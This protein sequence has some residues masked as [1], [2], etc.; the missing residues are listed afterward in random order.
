M[1]ELLDF[2]S[3]IHKNFQWQPTVWSALIYIHFV[4]L[5]ELSN[6]LLAGKI[7]SFLFCPLSLDIK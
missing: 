6:R 1:S 3:I 2:L 7:E 4:A 5:D